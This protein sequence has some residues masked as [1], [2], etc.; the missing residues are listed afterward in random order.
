M[1]TI[2]TLFVLIL[3]F[4][5]TKYSFVVKVECLSVGMDFVTTRTTRRSVVVDGVCSIR[6]T[7]I[8]YA[9]VQLVNILFLTSKMTAFHF[10]PKVC[11]YP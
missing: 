4:S 10:S 3:S 8:Q 6:L 11:R 2:T 9:I 7:E 1:T 5:T